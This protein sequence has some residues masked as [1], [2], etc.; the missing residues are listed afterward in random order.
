MIKCYTYHTN[1]IL[2]SKIHNFGHCVSHFHL[3]G[4]DCWCGSLIG[5]TMLCVPDR[6][7]T[8]F[9]LRRFFMEAHK[10]K[11]R[12]AMF[13]LFVLPGTLMLF[14]TTACKEQSSEPQEHEHTIIAIG[15]EKRPTCTESGMTEGAKCSVCGEII[16]QQKKIPALGHNFSEN[17]TIDVAPDCTT[18]GM[19]SRKCSRCGASTD[20]RSIQAIGH[21]W[22][23]WQFNDD[24][25][26]NKNGTETKSCEQCTATETR[27]KMGSALGHSYND[28]GVC[29]RCGD[30]NGP[31]IDPAEKPR[32]KGNKILFGSYPQSEVKDAA[33]KGALLAQV[34]E[35]P[36][37]SDRA[38]WNDYG[39][40]I[41]GKRQSYMWYI[42]LTYRDTKYRG[43]YFVDY[44]PAYVK[45]ESS[46][47]KSYQDDNGYM[48]DTVYWFRYDPIEWTILK[49][50]GGIAF[51]LCDIVI[52]A[53]EFYTEGHYPSPANRV[54]DGVA[55]YENNYKYSTVRNWLNDTFY[56]TAFTQYQQTLILQ[57]TVDNSAGSTSSSSNDK[58]CEDTEDKV[59]LLSYREITDTGYGFNGT[60]Q[61]SDTK[62]QK[63]TSAYA[64]SQGAF[65]SENG[66]GYQ[67]LRSPSNMMGCFQWAVTWNGSAN[68]NVMVDYSA[69]GI[70]PALRI[71]IPKT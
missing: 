25:S 24:A 5:D 33:T 52:D 2:S 27:E 39:Y 68:S 20:E 9:F 42:D 23:D 71:A 59:F 43:V 34:G 50:E 17:W 14:A 36:T 49:E 45:W 26:C 67:W 54:F 29:T 41:A 1:S 44:R 46:T 56:T 55:V 63:K 66:N 8:F 19:E 62:R 13:V 6:G 4:S 35:L 38:K 12:I 57:T 69:V 70:V 30:E 40:Y 15:V 16:S 47:E 53:Q 37:K 32:R 7:H 65:I 11:L 28:E 22:G 64:C 48:L 10:T 18:K 61:S 51:L 60:P 31:K 21:I 58:A 3:L